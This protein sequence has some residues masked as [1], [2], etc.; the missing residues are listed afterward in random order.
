VGSGTDDIFVRV[1][2]GK[3]WSVENG[4]WTKFHVTGAASGGSANHA[5]MVTVAD[6]SATAGQTI[7]ASSLFSVTDA[8]GDTITKYQFWDGT[9]GAGHFAVN[10]VTQGINQIIDVSAA[11]LAQTSFQVGSGTDFLYVR[12]FDGQNWS[13]ENGTWTSF[14]VSGAASSRNIDT[15]PLALWAATTNGDSFHFDALSQ[16]AA[17]VHDE[18]FL[19]PASNH[20]FQEWP[21]SQHPVD[22]K[23]ASA[24]TPDALIHTDLDWWNFAHTDHMI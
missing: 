2:D 12:A 6:V 22:P 1:F 20:I 9:A 3:N 14:H 19:E 7:A 15:D 16:G 24:G 5:P 17:P 11:Q 18:P 21:A 13:V 23:V 4:T 10:G 8:D